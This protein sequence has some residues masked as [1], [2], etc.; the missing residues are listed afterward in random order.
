MQ[1]VG[2]SDRDM[3]DGMHIR[4][5][6]HI[7]TAASTR[8]TKVNR[9]ALVNRSSLS[10]AGLMGDPGVAKSQML[11]FI[12]SVSPRGIYTSGKGTSAAPLFFVSGKQYHLPDGA[13]TSGVGLTAAVMRD[14]LTNVSE[15]RSASKRLAEN[16]V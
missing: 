14:K 1:L 9:R 16:V 11:R 7:C 10:F 13:G 3:K 6:I 8:P 12:A 15:G 5:D 4:G 2:G